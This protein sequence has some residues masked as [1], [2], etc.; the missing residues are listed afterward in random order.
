MRNG[1]ARRTPPTSKWISSRFILTSVAEWPLGCRRSWNND[2]AC[3]T[4]LPA[5]RDWREGQRI[6]PDALLQNRLREEPRPRRL[7]L[8]RRHYPR[9][10]PNLRALLRALLRM[11]SRGPRERLRPHPRA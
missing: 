11:R 5:S 9:R 3:S 7:A 4:I 8:A 6:K 2:V 10:V 1:R